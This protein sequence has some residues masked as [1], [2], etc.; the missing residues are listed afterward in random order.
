MTATSSLGRQRIDVVEIGD[1]GQPRHRHPDLPGGGPGCLAVERHGVLLGQQRGRGKEGHDAEAI[2]V[3]LGLDQVDGAVEQRLVAAEL[4]DDVSLDERSLGV[5]K[6]FMGADDCSDDAAPVY[7]AQQHDG[8]AGGTGEAHVGDVAL[9][10]VHFRGAARAF[11]NH[12]VGVGGY[13]REAVQDPGQERGLQGMVVAGSGLAIDAPL[14]DHLGPGLGRGLEQHRVHV[15]ARRHA[16][17]PGLQGLGAA[18]L[19]TVGGDGGV[20]GH[21]LGLEGADGEPAPPVGP[22]QPRHQQGL[23][24]VRPGA[25]DHQGPGDFPVKARQGR[26]SGRRPRGWRTCPR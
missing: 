23:A 7:V 5:L 11:D 1:A 20:V 21:V 4:V 25:L 16:G 9:A 12:Q 6:Q 22:A 24:H 10:Q 8:H 2:E 15:H 26:P 13:G 3:A 19:A 17:R 14:D 18:N